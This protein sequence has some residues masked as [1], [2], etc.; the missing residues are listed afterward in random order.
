M[1]LSLSPELEQRVEW[2][3]ALGDFQDSRQLVEEAVREFL[4]ARHAA[5][6]RGR[7]VLPVLCAR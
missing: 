2:E 4:D 6:R 1:T 7:V 5:C 3:I